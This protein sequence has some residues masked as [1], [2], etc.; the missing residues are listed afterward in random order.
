MKKIFSLFYILSFSCAFAFKPTAESLLRNL[1]N[2]DVDGKTV[3][4]SYSLKKTTPDNVQYYY[5]KFLFEDSTKPNSQICQLNFA[6]GVFNSKNIDEVLCLNSNVLLKSSTNKQALLYSVLDFLLRNSP[7]NMIK[8]LKSFGS[9][10]KTNRELINKSQ[11]FY[12]YQYKKY[13][14]S[15]ADG[16][17]ES[18][19]PL[20]TSN[21]DRNE[22]IKSI[23]QESYLR[24][25][26]MVRRVKNGTNFYWKLED[27]VVNAIFDNEKNRLIKLSVKLNDQSYDFLF[28]NYISVNSNFEHPETIEYILSEKEKYEIKVKKVQIIEDDS[29]D[30][31]R[32][33]KRYKEKMIQEGQSPLK[34]DILK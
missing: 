31:A 20:V 14:E 10:I 23:M 16:S 32:R 15:K 4:A 2:A 28:K 7:D 21:E 9:T 30:Y 11:N 24:D 5:N 25:D 33:I 1:N 26:P 29:N 19:N 22:K 6:S 12:L 3:V 34:A 17:V 8:T 18:Q 13:L 27:P